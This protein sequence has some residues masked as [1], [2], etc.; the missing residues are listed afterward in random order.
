LL[1]LQRPAIITPANRNTQPLAEFHHNNV[2]MIYRLFI[3]LFLTL[4]SCKKENNYKEVK[5]TLEKVYD[6]DQKLRTYNNY[7]SEQNQ[8]DRKNVQIVTKIID[9]IGWLG[10]NQIGEKANNA[11]FMAIQHANKLETMEKYLP[12]MKEAVK[13]GKAEKKQLAYLIDRV[14]IL[15]GRKQI[16][17]TQYSLNEKG[18]VV[19][20]NNID[21]SNVNDRRKSM[22]LIS[23]E[24][25]KEMI[26]TEK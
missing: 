7:S 11:L 10:K 12:V 9:S 23:I 25:Y 8:L 5:K 14:E 19:I 3:V 17:G 18:K 24:K 15:N 1:Y 22:E 4:I 20:L 13:N 26:E 6:D 21:S 2:K 16:Y